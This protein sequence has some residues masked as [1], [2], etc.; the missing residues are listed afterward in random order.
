M[1]A[2]SARTRRPPSRGVDTPVFLSVRSIGMLS[3]KMRVSS[4][5]STGVLPFFDALPRAADRVCR[6]GGDGLPQAKFAHYPQTRDPRP[7]DR[8][9]NHALDQ[10]A[11][12]SELNCHV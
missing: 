6:V 8:L 7:A 1:S 2:M 9:G 5:E 10:L 4:A 3:S 12:Q 11:P